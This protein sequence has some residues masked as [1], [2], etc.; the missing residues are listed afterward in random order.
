ML[1]AAFWGFVGGAALLVGAVLGLYAGVSR[2]LM[3]VVMA[4]GAGVLLSSVAFELM[5]EAYKVGGL[6]AAAPGLLLGAAVFYLADR[7]VNRRGGERRKSSGDQQGGSAAAIAI[8]ALLDGIPESAAIGISLIEGGGVGIALVAAVFLS[9]V[10]EG[11]SSAAGMRRAGRSP[12]YVLG[13]WGAVTLASTLSALLG[14]LFLA[15][16]SGNVVAGIQSFAAGAILTMLASTMMPE[17]YED[18]GP[19]V[20]VVTT[21]GFLLAFV[22]SRLA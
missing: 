21:V 8:G 5:E 20:G 11:L 13:L 12:A 9:N 1:E 19:V 15:G 6:D 17:A 4:L 14:Y 2:R 18:G 10:P 7:E 16:A 22:L 3:A